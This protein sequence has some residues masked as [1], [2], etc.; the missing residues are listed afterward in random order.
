MM[1]HLLHEARARGEP[2]TAL[3]A[4]EGGI[5]QRFGY[6]LATIEGSMT[7]ARERSSF[8]F[9]VGHYGTPRIVDEEEALRFM[10]DVY[11]RVA[12]AVPGHMSRS[13]DWWKNHRLV[14]DDG[15][16]GKSPIWRMVLEGNNGHEGYAIYR[17]EHRWAGGVPCSRLEVMEAA[18]STPEADAAVWRYLL[19]VDLV[20][21]V[22]CSNM[23]VDHPL[24]FWL[25]EPRRMRLRLADGLWVRIVDVA[26]ALEAR[27]YS[28][29]GSLVIDLQDDF[30][31]DNSGRYQ[32]NVSA[33][34][35]TVSKSRKAPQLELNMRDLSAIY[36]GGV[37]GLALTRAG[38]IHEI[39]SGAAGMAD[40]MFSW[41]QTAYCREIF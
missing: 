2:V 38:R 40:A 31:P 14:F 26:G 41:G 12:A 22:T 20:E 37:R 6:G 8:A 15:D 30:M 1:R 3:Y 27:R 5:Y 36:L 18:A 39:D 25:E 23:P 28:A 24:A 17:I 34:Q 21:E 7:L 13:V 11:D 29:D 32:M 4:S 10:P 33:G 35:A 16:N 19:G 9:D